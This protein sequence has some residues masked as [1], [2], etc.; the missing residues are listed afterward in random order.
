MSFMNLNA[1]WLTSLPSALSAQLSLNILGAT[2]VGIEELQL[3]MNSDNILDSVSEPSLVHQ[4]WTWSSSAHLSF[5]SCLLA[6]HLEMMAVVLRL[7]G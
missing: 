5:R 1:T 6:G 2:I 4:T 7:Q 3:E